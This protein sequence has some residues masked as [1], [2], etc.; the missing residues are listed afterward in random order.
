MISLPCGK[1]AAESLTKLGLNGDVSRPSTEF[2]KIL[3]DTLERVFHM[4]FIQFAM[5]CCAISFLTI[6]HGFAQER[7]AGGTLDTQVTWTALSDMAKAASDKAAA[8][9]TRVDQIVVCGKN[10]RIYAPGGVGAD[11]SGC[12]EAKAADGTTITN[13]NNSVKTN[14]TNVT[15]ILACNKQS[16]FY[17]GTVCTDLPKEDKE[18]SVMKPIDT[19]GWQLF[20]VGKLQCP[21]KLK[22]M[23]VRVNFTTNK[24]QAACSLKENNCDSDYPSCYGANKCTFPQR[25]GWVSGV[26]TCL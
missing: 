16:K 3:P 4:R 18:E 22:M 6:S 19:G 26:A 11:A 25:G 7:A 1:A 17:N 20:A 2:H 23:G 5:T 12:M 9:N 15:N 21:G 24:S 14:T 8:V 10:G 13:I